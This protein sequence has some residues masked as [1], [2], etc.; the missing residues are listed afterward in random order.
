MDDKIL[1]VYCV[2]ADILNAI[3][4]KPGQKIIYISGELSRL[5]C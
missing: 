3:G 5:V 4:H 1:A 2:S